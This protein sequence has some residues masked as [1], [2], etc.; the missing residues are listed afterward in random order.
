MPTRRPH[1]SR[2]ASLAP[3][4]VAA[5][6]ALGACA[7]EAPSA[8]LAG[9]PA[10]GIPA[11]G[12]S[13]ALEAPSLVPLDAASGDL[14]LRPATLLACPA[15][16]VQADTVT[17]D[18]AGGTFTVG[19]ARLVVPPGALAEGSAPRTFEMR[20]PGDGTASV[21]FTPV[22]GQG[23]IVFAAGQPARLTLDYTGCTG[24]ELTRKRIAYTSDLND[25]VTGLPTVFE[26]VLGLDDQ[27]SNTITAGIG[28]FSRY[29]VAW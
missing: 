23:G 27:S 2:P 1:C 8:P 7:G 9:A 6:L 3:L 26:A 11:G 4:A 22:D 18:A 10:S 20:T 15:A 29:A 28:H 5:L 14:L 16:A 19:R 13:A 12:T 21:V 17:A 24:A 25:A